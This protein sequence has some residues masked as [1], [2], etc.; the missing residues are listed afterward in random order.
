MDEN[1]I[2]IIEN[3]Y[4]NDCIYSCKKSSLVAAKQS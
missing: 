1:F 2:F 4:E 3:E